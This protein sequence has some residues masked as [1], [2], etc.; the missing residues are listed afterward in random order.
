MK[1]QNKLYQ[2]IEVI[3][4]SLVL[5][6]LYFSIVWSI[7]KDEFLKQSFFVLGFIIL[8]FFLF[9]FFKKQNK[10]RKENLLKDVQRLSLKESINNF[11]NRAGMEKGKLAWK[12]VD[13]GFNRDK[14][15][16]FLRTLQKEGLKVK[17]IDDLEY[18]LIHFIDEKEEAILT[19]N[20][21]NKQNSFNSL[22]G[23]EFEL[24]LIRLFDSMGYIVEHCGKAGDQGGDLILNKGSQRILIQ[25]KCYTNNS[26]NDSVQ[27]A[28]AAKK[29]YDS[30]EAWVVC[31][32][33]FTRE[34]IELANVHEVKLV[35]KKELQELLLTYLKESWI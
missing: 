19:G 34:A 12:Y 30:N 1:E 7:N 20:L 33:N 3:F 18:L 32:S 28:V 5:L 14:M 17:N 29:Y 10:R 23:T 6:A 9:R 16:I 31:S 15:D 22:S 27:Q 21:K 24:L 25:A 2:Y 13:Y 4:W 35:G 26:G 8:V 11:I